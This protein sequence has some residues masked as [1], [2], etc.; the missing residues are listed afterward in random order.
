MSKTTMVN[1]GQIVKAFIE[2]LNEFIEVEGDL[3]ETISVVAAGGKKELGHIQIK[4][5]V[6]EHPLVE[7]N[8]K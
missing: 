3:P 1:G 4:K 7:G 5:V 6:F 2:A 8:N